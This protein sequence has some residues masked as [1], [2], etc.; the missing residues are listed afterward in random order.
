LKVERFYFLGFEEIIEL[1][2]L[3]S[4]VFHRCLTSISICNLLRSKL[5]NQLPGLSN[6]RST[7]II[8][9]RKMYSSTIGFPFAHKH[10]L[11][12][13]NS[14]NPQLISKTKKIRVFF[15]N[16]KT[17]KLEINRLIFDDFFFP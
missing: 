15:L 9:N 6:P 7:Y 8:L 2:M 14:T 5:N 16:L 17:K 4:M 3:K 11:M 13:L 12:W 10:P 1:K